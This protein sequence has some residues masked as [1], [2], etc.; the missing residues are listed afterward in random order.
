[1]LESNI[2]KSMHMIPKLHLDN[3]S[4]TQINQEYQTKKSSPQVRS[5]TNQTYKYSV[6]LAKKKSPVK[7]SST[8]E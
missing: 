3:I 4:S 1:M 6:N 2:D 7:E 8:R 5:P